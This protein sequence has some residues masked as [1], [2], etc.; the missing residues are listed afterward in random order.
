M[1]T[2]WSDIEMYIDG[3]VC[4]VL[5][6]LGSTSAIPSI[7]GMLVHPDMLPAIQ[8]FQVG[9]FNTAESIPESLPKNYVTRT[10][11]R[12]SLYLVTKAMII[13]LS[14]LM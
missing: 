3:F 6:F 10:K 5:P 14:G 12:V 7:A 2:V 1:T 4:L 8:S 13:E 11:K 9:A